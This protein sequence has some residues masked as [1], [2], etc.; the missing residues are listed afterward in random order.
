MDL[1]FIGRGSA[2][3]TKEGNN[4]AFYKN[5]KGQMLLIDCGETTFAAIKQKNMLQDVNEIFVAITHTHADHFGSFASLALFVFFALKKKVNLILTHSEKQN[6]LLQTLM[7]GMGVAPNQVNLISCEEFTNRMPE[8]CNF[9]FLE[10]SH[11]EE[12]DSFGLVFETKDGIVYYSADT[13]STKYLEKYLQVPNLDKIYMDTC[14]AD[15]EGNVHVSFRRACEVVP[16]AKRSQYFAMHID[17]DDL[18][19]MLTDAGFHYVKKFY[20]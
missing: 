17:N 1:K 19:A 16:Q 3:N 2:F 7:F 18:F 8:F 9:A 4:S 5:E 15:Y 14:K 20:E 12:F 10:T 6:L 11:V 13:N